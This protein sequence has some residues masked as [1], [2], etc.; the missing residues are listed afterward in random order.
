MRTRSFSLWIDAL[1]GPSSTISP[2]MSA[3]KRPSDVPPVQESSGA[4]PVTASHRFRR[5]VDQ[6]AARGEERRAEAG[7]GEIVV[8]A[9]PRRIASKRC[10]SDSRV[11]SGQKRKLNMA[12]SAPGITLVAPVPAWMLEHCQVVGGKYSLPSSHR[13]AASSAKRGR[14]EVDRI[15]REMRVGDVPLDALD[16]QRAR[17]RA[18]PAV[19]DHV[20]EALDRRRLADDAIVDALARGRELLD[21]LDRAVDRRAFLVG[22]QQQ[23][24]RAGR[25]GWAATNASIAVTNAAS[26]AFMSAAPRP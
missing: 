5:D 24:D 15:L 18:A 1:T 7:P 17:Q 6:P 14:R 2:Q 20:A 16:D 13:V 19:L 21:D 3:M 12:S 8:E 25:A 23:R 26:E 9:V 11:L 4:M 10:T 22:R